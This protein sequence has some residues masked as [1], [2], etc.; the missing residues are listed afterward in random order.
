MKKLATLRELLAMRLLFA[1]LVNAYND[2]KATIASLLHT[3]KD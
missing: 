1:S 2:S 3:Q